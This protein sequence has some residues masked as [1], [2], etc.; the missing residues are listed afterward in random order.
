MIGRSKSLSSAMG[1][2][3]HRYRGMTI[4]ELLVVIAIMS[5]LAALLLPA[6]QQAREAAR[7]AECK[8]HLHQISLAL[9]EHC[10]AF[11]HFPSSGWGWR[12]PPFPDHG[13]GEHQPGSWA[14]TILPFL[15]AEPLHSSSIS[16]DA[17][18]G[19]V[20]PV[21]YC[22][23]RR[24]AELYP[25]TNPD[26]AAPQVALVA[27]CDYATS[28]G[29]HDEPNAAGPGH[30]FVQPLALVDG[31]NDTW[32]QTQGVVRDANG[33]VFQRSSIR[34]AD[35][36]DGASQT[37]LVG[38]KYLNPDD[39]Q[40]GAGLGDMESVY[41]GDNDDSS[42]VTYPADGPPRRD[43]SG[44]SSRTLFGS[45]HPAGCN[46]ALADGS[47]RTV[48][49]AIDVEVHRRLGNRRDGQPVAGGP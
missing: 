19:V 20:L 30:A 47:I 9:C 14:Y 34:L 22:P 48:S 27:K 12:W 37:Y 11:G 4:V 28:T 42:R 13:D 7:A 2:G 1:A 43:Q 21:F 23:S 10:E 31:D 40:S 18:L 33:L 8:N 5:M 32:W 16:S 36:L 25:L 17:R 46:F 49:Y 29:D 24:P 15:E 35:L 41:H 39:Y 38:E 45:A 6:V 3:E 44:F 26:V